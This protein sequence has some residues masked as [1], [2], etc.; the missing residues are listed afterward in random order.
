MLEVQNNTSV[1]TLVLPAC[2]LVQTL[3]HQ[4]LYQP[5]RDMHKMK[6]VLLPSVNACLLAKLQSSLVWNV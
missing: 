6:L 1:N 2:R 5:F 4:R 3:S